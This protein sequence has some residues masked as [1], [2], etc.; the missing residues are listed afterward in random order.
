MNTISAMMRRSALRRVQSVRLSST[1]R[2]VDLKNQLDKDAAEGA[3][4]FV[5]KAKRKPDWL[6]AV[7]DYCARRRPTLV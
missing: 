6:K 3:L 1:S 2:L 7:R 5:T 4:P